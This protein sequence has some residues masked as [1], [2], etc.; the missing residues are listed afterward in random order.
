MRF[1]KSS[2]KVVNNIIT[3]GSTAPLPDPA[4]KV[5]TS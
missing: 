2:L 4:T 3:L 5:R 1:I